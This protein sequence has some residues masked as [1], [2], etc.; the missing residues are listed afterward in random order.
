MKPGQSLR[1]SSHDFCTSTGACVEFYYYMY[2]IVEVQTQLRVLVEGPSGR[3]VPLWTRTGVQSQA[4][5]FGSVTVPSGGSQPS[6]V[7]KATERATLLPKS[8]TKR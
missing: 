5:L 6:K 7:S 1:L 2:G 3:A 4:W 8:A